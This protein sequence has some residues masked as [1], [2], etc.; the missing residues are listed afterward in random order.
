MD[1]YT[2]HVT[3]AKFG[4]QALNFSIL[5]CVFTQSRGYEIPIRKEKKEEAVGKRRAPG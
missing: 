5:I 4:H 2:I 1:H 3:E